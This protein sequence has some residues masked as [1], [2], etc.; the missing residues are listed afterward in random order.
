MKKHPIS[1]D[2]YEIPYLSGKWGAVQFIVNENQPDGTGRLVLSCLS[3]D[4]RPY[5]KADLQDQSAW[6]TSQA[7]ILSLVSE[8]GQT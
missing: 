4:S 7:S 6:A 5:F 3:S 1:Q 8:W 2:K